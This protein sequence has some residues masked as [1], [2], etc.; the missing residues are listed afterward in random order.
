MLFVCACFDQPNRRI[1]DPFVRCCG[2]GAQRWTSLSPQ[3]KTLCLPPDCVCAVA[4]TALPSLS[5]AL[6]SIRRRTFFDAK[7]SFRHCRTN[8]IS[9]FIEFLH[10]ANHRGS[11]LCNNS[12]FFRLRFFIERGVGRHTC[13]HFVESFLRNIPKRWHGRGDRHTRLFG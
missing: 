8:E 9:R 13:V 12:I 10:C 2:R 6:V 5:E 4:Y 7:T 11:A 3:D 1:R